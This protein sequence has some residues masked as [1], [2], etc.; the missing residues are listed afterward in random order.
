M[1][2]ACPSVSGMASV[3]SDMRVTTSRKLNALFPTGSHAKANNG[4]L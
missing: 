3:K 2:G 1:Y 4:N